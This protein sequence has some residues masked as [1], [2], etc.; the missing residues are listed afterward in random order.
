MIYLI[1]FLFI[2][3]AQNMLKVDTDFRHITVDLILTV[4]NFFHRLLII[5]FKNYN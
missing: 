4:I 1:L 5:N 3:F 2:C